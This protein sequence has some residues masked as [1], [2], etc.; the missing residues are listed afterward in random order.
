MLPPFAVVM[1]SVAPGAHPVS[2]QAFTRPSQEAMKVILHGTSRNL[3]SSTR[4]R[5]LSGFRASA[6][7][8]SRRGAAR[9][10]G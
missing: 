5:P 8:G 9:L 2:L 3:S 10:P 1:S 4:Y 7:P 6:F